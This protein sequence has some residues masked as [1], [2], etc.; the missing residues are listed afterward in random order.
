MTEIARSRRGVPIRLT[1]ERWAHVAEGHAELAGLKLEVLET[2]TRAESVRAGSAGE[3]LAVRQFMDKK[4]VVVY[5]E[6]GGDGFVITAFMTSKEQS[7]LK[8]K[9]V[10]P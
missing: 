9:Q 10:W 5:R 2:V 8:R 3:L 4:M 6:S 1:D 7:L